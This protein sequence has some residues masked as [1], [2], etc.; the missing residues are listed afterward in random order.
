[1]NKILHVVDVNALNNNQK[2]QALIMDGDKA[3]LIYVQKD[4]DGIIRKVINTSTK[5]EYTAVKPY[6][7]KA[8]DLNLTEK[9]T[10]A[11]IDSASGVNG[12]GIIKV[13]RSSGATNKQG[14]V[15]TRDEQVQQGLARVIE[16]MT[17]RLT[18]KP[19]SINDY[20]FSVYSDSGASIKLEGE[21]T[22]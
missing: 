5:T 15:L 11:C 14:E 19:T 3:V 20:R 9:E 6:I 1:M 10:R 2:T 18:D 12:M 22:L 8:T 13:Y 16:V 17:E 4:S 21:Y 7:N